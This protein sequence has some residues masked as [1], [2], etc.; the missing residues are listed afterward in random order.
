M[1]QT[2]ALEILKT[3]ANVFLTGE[4]GAGKS[5]TVNQYVAYLRSCGIEPA[6][7]AST[8]IA[9]THIDGMTIHSWSGV[10]VA[11]GMTRKEAAMVAGRKKIEKRLAEAKMLIIDEISMLSAPILSMVDAVCRAGRERGMPFGGLQVVL[12]GDFFQLPPISHDG[13]KAPFAYASDAWAELNPVVCYLTDQ[14][15]QDDPAYLGVLSAIRT[16]RFGASHR[17][18]LSLRRHTIEQ[19]PPDVPKLFSH[20][21][22][23]DRINMERLRLLLGDTAAFQMES[24]GPAALV[25]VLKRHCLSP[26]VLALKKGAVV[27][28]TKN[29]PLGNFVNGTL[30]M[31]H[32]FDKETGCPTVETRKGNRIAIKPMEWTVEEQGRT[33]ARVAQI[34]LR[35]AWAMTVHKSQGMSMD[36]A[37][38][39]LSDAFEYGQGYVALSRVRR[40]SGL[41]LL[42]ANERAFMVSAEILEKDKRFCLMSEKAQEKLCSMDKEEIARKHVAFIERC[43]GHAPDREEVSD[44]ARSSRHARARRV[45]DAGDGHAAI[46]EKHPNAFRPWSGEDDAW[47]RDLF[48]QGQATAGLAK[49]FG[50][51]PGAIRSRLLKLGL[52][53]YNTDTGRYDTKA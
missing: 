23:V 38:V 42:G 6:I 19:T 45:C 22:D 46:R 8:G 4:P 53:A 13:S 27:M 1:T 51:K 15:R 35:L 9:A 18:H 36:A 7:T 25:T 5:H 34:P 39:D 47:L 33:R 32:D 24:F 20:N 40:L 31:V 41:Y 49:H 43:G 3:G 52:I 44:S 50:R 30:G 2:E 14:Y 11:A 12:V 26:E 37:V 17:E 10:G 21:A 16:N 28:C 29:H 48:K